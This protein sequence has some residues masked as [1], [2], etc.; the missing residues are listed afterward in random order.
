MRYRSDFA[1]YF[2]TADT[3]QRLAHFLRAQEADDRSTSD[4]KEE[5]LIVFSLEIMAPDR[6]RAALLRTLGSVLEP[7]RVAPGCRS[8]RL[9]TDLDKRRALILIEEWE[10]REEFERNLDATKLNTIV[11]AIEL[12]GERPEIWI[13][14]TER[15]EGVDA[16]ALHHSVLGEQE[17]RGQ[18]ET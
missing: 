10:S 2:H 13:D 15:E 3:F 16:L 8:A 17:P 1:D 9:F 4:G 14:T 18:R 11:G 12:S 5:P 7:T 6:V